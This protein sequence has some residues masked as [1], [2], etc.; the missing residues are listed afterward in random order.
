MKINRFQPPRE[1]AGTIYIQNRLLF[2]ISWLDKQE[3]CEYQIYL[4][5]IAGI[6]VE[7][8][9]QMIEGKQEHES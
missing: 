6:K 9:R 3:F 5:N 7:P 8:T 2:P 4:E 1:I